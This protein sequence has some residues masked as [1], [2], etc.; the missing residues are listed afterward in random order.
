MAKVLRCR[1]LG[2][3]CS[4]EGRAETM[5]EL[6]V[7]VTQHAKE[8]H[9]MAEIPPELQQAALAIVREE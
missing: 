8:A 1:D 7:Q 4:W 9:G 2:A 6:M 3:D 5:D